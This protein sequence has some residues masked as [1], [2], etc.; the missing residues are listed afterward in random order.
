[1]SEQLI[2]RWVLC[3]ELSYTQMVMKVK[4]RFVVAEDRHVIVGPTFI[5]PQAGDLL[6]SATIAIV[7]QVPL[8]RLWH[9][10][11]P[12]R[13]VELTIRS[14]LVHRILLPSLYTGMTSRMQD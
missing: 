10:I 2:V 7:G 5:G 14:F 3:L 6:H 1:M 9:A 13:M 8:E 11:L 4:L 12:G